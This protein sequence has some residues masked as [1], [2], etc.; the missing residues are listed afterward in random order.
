MG[1]RG[2]GDVEGAGVD[3]TNVCILFIHTVTYC[4]A[5]SRTVTGVPS[6]EPSQDL[7]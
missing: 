6:V 3:P 1:G 7:L 2:G 4:V 5:P